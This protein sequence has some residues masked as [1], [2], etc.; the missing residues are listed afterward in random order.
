MT[1]DARKQL[2]DFI[3]KK[4]FNPV[5]S[6]D[7]EKYDEDDREKLKDI[8]LKTKN[9]QK[10]FENDFMT[11]EKVKKGYLSDVRSEAAKKLNAELKK[12]ELPILPDFKDEFKD[13][14]EKLGV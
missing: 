10:Q 6:A 4:V 3:N 14:C 8:Q 2:L 11:A 13:L 12:L 9:E 5:L 7:P 1:N